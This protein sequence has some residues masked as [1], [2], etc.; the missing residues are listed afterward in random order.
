MKETS[1]LPDIWI[2]LV[3]ARGKYDKKKQND[4]PME[5]MHFAALIDNITYLVPNL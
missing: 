2:S 4:I 1:R 3:N 5:N